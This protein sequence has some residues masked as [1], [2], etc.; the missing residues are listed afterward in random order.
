[1]HLETDT[2][3]LVAPVPTA[4]LA[5]ICSPFRGSVWRK[6]RR[7]VTRDEIQVALDAGDLFPPDGKPTAELSRR[8]HVARIAWFVRYGWNDPIQIDLGVPIF[9]GHVD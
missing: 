2:D 5:E 1:M 4:A 9:G 6:V 3:D 8:Q 7:P